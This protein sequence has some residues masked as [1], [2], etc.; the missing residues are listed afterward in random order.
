MAN[1][2]ERTVTAFIN[3]QTGCRLRIT[4]KILRQFGPTLGCKA[5][6][7]CSRLASLAGGEHVLAE[8]EHC[9][10]SPACK[11]RFKSKLAEEISGEMGSRT[12]FMRV[13][14]LDPE[15]GCRL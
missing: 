7:K 5:C 13:T 4:S 9:V 15:A 11:E 2:S 10:H 12:P 3:P 14:V 1:F 6:D 8:G